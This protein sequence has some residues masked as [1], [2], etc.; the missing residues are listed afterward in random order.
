MK[1]NIQITMAV[2]SLDELRE[3][4]LRQFGPLLV[5]LGVS[6]PTKE[7][8]PERARDEAPVADT[9]VSDVKPEPVEAE[10]PKR[11]RKGKDTPAGEPA[12]ASAPPTEASPAAAPGAEPAA[13][14]SADK[15]MTAAEAEAWASRPPPE[16]ARAVVATLEAGPN[17]LDFTREE[18]IDAARAFIAGHKD[19]KE[20][21]NAIV[22]GLVASMGFPRVSELPDDRM[23]EFLTLLDGA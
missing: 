18:V 19:G 5:G 15:P 17:T 1:T 4:L 8:A 13:P 2:Q 10:K 20:K 12:G 11:T 9:Y 7:L 22:K 14:V 21:G 16:K 23:Q 6:Q 3:E